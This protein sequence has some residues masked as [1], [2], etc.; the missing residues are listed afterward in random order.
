[1][2][3]LKRATHEHTC[4]VISEILNKLEPGDSFAMF[5]RRQ[6]CV[7][8]FHISLTETGN[9]GD[10]LSIIVGRF[11]GTL[12]PRELFDQENEIESYFSEVNFNFSFFSTN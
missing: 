6:N 9:T 4:T 1:M 5:I 3:R 11:I 12:H 7:I 2:D 10:P 8:M